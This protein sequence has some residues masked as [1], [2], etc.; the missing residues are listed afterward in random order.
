M[1][2][3]LK[4]Q[5]V[6][7]ETQ[8]IFDKLPNI[9]VI[10]SDNKFHILMDSNIPDWGTGFKTELDVEK[11][12]NEHDIENA[13]LS[14]VYPKE[15][16]EAFNFLKVFWGFNQVDEDVLEKEMNN[17]SITIISTSD[18]VEVILDDEVEHFNSGDELV[19]FMDLLMR[20]LQCEVLSSEDIKNALKGRSIVLAS[21]T[22]RDLAKN[23]IRVK[24]SNLWSYCIFI[25]D[26]KDKTGRV[27]VQ[28]KGP[29]GGPGDIYSYYDV[30]ITL[31]RRFVTAP[32]KGHFL[33]QYI[34][35][36]FPYDKLTGDKK[37]KMRGG[38]N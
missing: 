19:R 13:T 20:D 4:K 7:G 24:S 5:N 34:R 21:I 32:S 10:S 33:W 2:H 1:Y 35:G 15:I 29:K 6:Y 12:V 17:S 11:F 14:E 26:R 28:F 27:F 22:S 36:K 25:A 8:Y 30:P 38:I 37:T 23:M 3:E 16:T 31:W 9:S 18:N